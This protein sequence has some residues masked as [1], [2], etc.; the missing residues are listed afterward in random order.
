MS[1]GTTPPTSRPDYY[2]GTLQWYTPGDLELTKD[3]RPAT[4][5][6]SDVAIAEGKVRIYERGM[7]LWVGIGGSLGKVGLARER[8][9]SN[10]QI[11]GIRFSEEI[12]SEYGFWWMRG[13][14]GQLRAAAPQATLPILSQGRLGEFPIAYPGLTEQRRIVARLDDLQARAD[15]VKQLHSQTAAELDAL[16]P[17][18][19]DKAFKGEL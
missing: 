2:G 1:T 19:L 14:Y 5:T 6:V 7:V 4:K 12:D 17:S 11:T 3:L 13:L 8:C 15:S 9:S 16:L 18:I 10:Q